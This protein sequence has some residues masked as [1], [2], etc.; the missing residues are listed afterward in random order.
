MQGRNQVTMCTAELIGDPAAN[1]QLESAG[2]QVQ[3]TDLRQGMTRTTTTY[4]QD[5][6]SGQSVTGRLLDLMTINKSD[7]TAV[8]LSR[9]S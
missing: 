5:W 9:S 8:H 6:K 4:G 2:Q 3:A 1:K 7:H